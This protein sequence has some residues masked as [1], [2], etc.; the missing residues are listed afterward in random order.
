[1]NDPKEQEKFA[2]DRQPMQFTYGPPLTNNMS[3]RGFITAGSP[4]AQMFFQNPPAP[5]PGTVWTCTCGTQSSGKFC[6]ECG[7]PRNDL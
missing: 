1:M 6:P 3:S 4:L 5:Q 7:K 2:P